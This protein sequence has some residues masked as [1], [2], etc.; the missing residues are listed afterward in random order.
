M[1]YTAQNVRLRLGCAKSALY[2][3]KSALYGTKCMLEIR[4]CKKCS[5]RHKM[6]AGEWDM[7]KVLYTAQNVRWRL[8]CVKSALYGTKCTLESGMCKKCSIQ[9]KMYARE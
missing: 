4:M 3:A 8:G 2:G 6:H 1:L 9:H 5:I 7:Q